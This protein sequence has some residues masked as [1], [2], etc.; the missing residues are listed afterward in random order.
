MLSKCCQNFQLSKSQKHGKII[1]ISFPLKS[2]MCHS[3]LGYE[4]ICNMCKCCCWT[5]ICKWVASYTNPSELC[6]VIVKWQAYIPEIHEVWIAYKEVGRHCTTSPC[7]LFALIKME[8][9]ILVHFSLSVWFEIKLVQKGA[10][11]IL[12]QMISLLVEMIGSS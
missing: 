3:L 12:R 1:L 11:E 7:Q 5:R 10:Q 8:I 9:I 6:Q 2:Q 4:T